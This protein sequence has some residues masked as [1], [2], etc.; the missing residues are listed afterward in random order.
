M[1]LSKVIS[2][3]TTFT[4]L[5]SDV[6]ILFVSDSKGNY[7]KSQYPL[8]TLRAKQI[9]WENQPGRK[10]G[11]GLS[12]LRVKLDKFSRLTGPKCVMFWHGTC[13]LTLKHGPHIFKIFTDESDAISF[14]KPLIDDFFLYCTNVSINEIYHLGNP[15][16]VYK[17]MEYF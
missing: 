2:K 1:S 12:C 14:F 6:N 15:P 17:T 3:T 11:C 9:M 13:D 10:F 7:L 8:L 4:E 16:Y 5:P